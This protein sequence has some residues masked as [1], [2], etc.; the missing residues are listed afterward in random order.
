MITNKRGAR[1]PYSG[2]NSLPSG[3]ANLTAR[4]EL[5]LHPSDL[6]SC[7]KHVSEDSQRPL[8]GKVVH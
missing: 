6:G 3:K 7:L 4:Q 2:D 5:A 1:N 8:Q